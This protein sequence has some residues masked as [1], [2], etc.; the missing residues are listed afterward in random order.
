MKTNPKIT[1]NTS[2]KGLSQIYC[3]HRRAHYYATGAPRGFN[4]NPRKTS[5]LVA[6]ANEMTTP[7]PMRNILQCASL[8]CSRGQEKFPPGFFKPFHS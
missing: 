7:L 4:W 3:L 2:A 6:Y 5:P 1:H 8:A